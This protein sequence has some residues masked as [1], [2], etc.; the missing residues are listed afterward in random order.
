M[1]A[2]LDSLREY[3]G[4]QWTE[5]SR[6]KAFDAS[7]L[8]QITSITVSVKEVK[9]QFDSEMHEVT[10][11]EILKKNGKTVYAQLDKNSDLEEGDEVDPKSVEIIYFEDEDGGEH[12]RVD[13]KLKREK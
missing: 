4:S 11:L 12:H 10:S 7:D 9:S 5:V 6:E 1:S 2:F 13:G 8:K 3:G